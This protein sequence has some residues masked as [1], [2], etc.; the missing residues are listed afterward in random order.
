MDRGLQQFYVHTGKRALDLTLTVL[1]CA[2]LAPFIAVV[3]SLV[4]LK[5]GPPVLFLHTRPGFRG[6]PF[7]MF[8][9]RTMTGENDSRGNPLPDEMRITPFGQILR[10][11]SIDEL[12]EL[13]NVLRGEMSLVGP[14]PL[15]TRYIGRYS[16]EQM[17]RHDV[18]PGITG[19]AQVHGRNDMTW[20]KKFELDVWYVD[21]V[22]LLLDLRI[23]FLTAVK[24]LTREGIHQSGFF[25]SEEFTGGDQQP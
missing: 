20:G 14:R 9:F 1:A 8:K 4:W 17:R 15:L 25:S 21:H 5:L 18:L 24:T 23:L 16:P 13:I 10:N 22:S 6:R 11:A 3:A 7:T 19:W 2:I 12:P